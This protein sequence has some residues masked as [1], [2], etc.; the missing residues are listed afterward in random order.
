MTG[1]MSEAIELI[2]RMCG[3]GVVF[4]ANLHSVVMCG[5]GVFFFVLLAPSCRV[6]STLKF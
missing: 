3:R 5:F 6:E 2:E 1:V 4:F